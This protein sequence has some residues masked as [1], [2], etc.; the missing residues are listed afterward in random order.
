[1][2][3][4]LAA[5]EVRAAAAGRLTDEQLVTLLDGLNL[6][7]FVGDDGEVD[8]AKVVK[9]VDG[10]APKTDAPGFPDLGQGA[11]Q[12]LALGSDPLLDALKKTV[13]A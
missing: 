7:A 11:R 3:S 10:I 6:S 12:P 8:Q 4:K 9:F 2:G 13:G 5:A 1:L